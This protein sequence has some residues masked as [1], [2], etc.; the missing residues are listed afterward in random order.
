M[1]LS[2]DRR[3]LLAKRLNAALD[4]LQLPTTLALELTYRWEAVTE[5]DQAY[6]TIV[7]L[8]DSASRT[9]DITLAREW[10]R[11]A[12]VRFKMKYRKENNGISIPGRK[13]G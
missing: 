11:Q 10:S 12:L 1:G 8:L 4:K 13:P 2:N 3:I 7:D 5:R 6:D 9:N